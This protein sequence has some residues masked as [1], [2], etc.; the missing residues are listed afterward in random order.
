M[1]LSQLLAENPIEKLAE[2]V[3]FPEILFRPLADFFCLSSTPSND[4]SSH[5]SRLSAVCVRL[6]SSPDFPAAM[7]LD[8]TLDGK[9][10][11]E[12]SQ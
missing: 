7:A 12:S 9:E 5:D 10:L 4:A 3:R 1:K 11:P 2:R 6:L 8:M